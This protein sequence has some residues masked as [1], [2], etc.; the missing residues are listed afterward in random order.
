MQRIFPV[1]LVLLLV[2]S[3]SGCITQ[4]PESILEE[5]RLRTAVRIHPEHEMGYLRLAQ[6][7]ENQRR[8]AETLYV[9]K[10]GQ[11]RVPD[12]LLMVRLEGSLYQSQDDKE[13]VET[14]YEN[15]FLQYP[16]ETVFLLDRARWHWSKARPNKAL[17]DLETLFKLDPENFE[18]HY[19]AGLIRIGIGEDEKALE[20]LI[21]AGSLQDGH[22]E[23]W[24]HIANLWNR[25][26]EPEK[27]LAAIRKALELA[28]ES[29]P[30]LQQYVNYLEA[31]L[32]THQSETIAE[33]RVTLKQLMWLESE[34][35]WVLA[36]SGYLSWQEGE[37][38]QAEAQLTRALELQPDY[39][40]ARF[41]LGSVYMSRKQWQSA[42]ESF[43]AGLELQPD[44]PWAL[45]QLAFAFEMKGET[46]KAILRYE[47][48]LKQ[49]PDNV[50]MLLRLLNLYWQEFR[51]DRIEHI[52]VSTQ[53]KIPDNLE[54]ANLLLKYRLS[55]GQLEEALSLL[56]SLKLH[57][58]NSVIL[59]RIGQMEQQRGD[60]EEAR[61]WLNKTLKVDSE[62]LDAR[63]RLIQL[64]LKQKDFESA[65]QKLE[66]LLRKKPDLEWALAQSAGLK[67]K[68]GRLTECR[69][70]L[71]QALRFHPG[72][73]SLLKIQ[74]LLLEKEEQWQ[75]ALH[76]FQK[77]ESLDAENSLI[78]TH[79]GMV[80]H[81]LNQDD[82]ARKHLEKALLASENN[83]WAFLLRVQ[84]ENVPNK[85]R[86]LGNDRQEVEPILE[87]LLYRRFEQG[88]EKIK[89]SR[90]DPLSRNALKNLYFLLQDSGEQLALDPEDVASPAV[91]PWIRYLWG[92]LHERQ[93]N[94]G[95]ALEHYLSVLQDLPRDPWVHLR[96][97]ILQEQQGEQEQALFH[98]KIASEAYPDSFRILF[99]RSIVTMNLLQEEESIRIH[100]KMI[101][102]RPEHALSLN[103]L[104]WMYLTAKDRS[105]RQPEK[106]LELAL[107]SVELEATIDHID[108]LAEAYFQTGQTGKA[109]ETL[110][111]GIREA[112]YP[113]SRERYLEGQYRRFRKGDTSVS[114]P[115]VS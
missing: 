44:H 80:R 31:R 94:T 13:K 33:L 62:N 65:E 53:K 4:S 28:P 8:Y 99:R 95:K 77:I 78:Q 49:T 24:S 60:L 59:L 112:S 56:K 32:D 76:T 107:K 20:N 115:P 29:Y 91:S 82:A 98:Y 96:T 79:L 88:W 61:L 38:E 48:L 90:L 5:R 3:F 14:F 34:D 92:H 87:E 71:E 57:H 104:A 39:P 47:A 1:F 109:I 15:I 72:S 105:L 12:S 7:L 85:K 52:L 108:T 27:A 46:E 66:H 11:Q 100:Q 86:W 23:I 22:A 6:F 75:E 58:S 93:G 74:G 45:Q 42:I 67:L 83:L 41:R 25:L 30:Y 70:Q 16:E 21:K 10:Q 111:K 40:W 26:G 73:V 64:D 51:F 55:R 37:L 2:L 35:S 63:I 19:L 89:A 113:K 43:E 18:A 97:G 106:A 102:L 69:E 9:L 101:E 54:L 50:P 103:N 114:P 17:Q 68:G 84:L 81:L 36:H 110:R